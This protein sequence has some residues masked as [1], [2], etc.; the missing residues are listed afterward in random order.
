MVITGHTHLPRWIDAREQRVTYLNAGAWA[1]VIGLRP[2]FLTADAFG[3]VYESLTT[4]TM[5]SLDQASPSIDG[6]PVPLVL[7]ACAAAHVEEE[8]TFT[9]VELLRV[10]LTG[11]TV[12][13]AR[14]DPNQ[15]ALEWR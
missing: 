10:V 4:A 15:S 8:K 11:A 9:R 1:R 14:V 12:D 13:F 2:E 5:N 6:A 3:A 7:D